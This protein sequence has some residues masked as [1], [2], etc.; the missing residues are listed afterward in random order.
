M[1]AAAAL[2]L[3]AL[4][5]RSTATFAVSAGAESGE[6]PAAGAAPDTVVIVVRH[7]EKADAPRD[8]P[9]L[10][11]RGTERALALAVA[12]ADAGIDAIVTSDLERSRQ[13][14]A[15]AARRYGIRPHAEPLGAAD[16]VDR[17]VAAVAALL[18]GELAGDTV[19]VVG[20]SHTIPRLLE[21]LGSPPVEELC[22]DTDYSKMFVVTLREGR[23][24]RLL[25]TRYGSPDPPAPR[26]C[27]G[28]REAPGR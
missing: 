22:R 11:V 18:R 4:A 8:D 17:H 16:D 6:R 10:T 20:H 24:T 1:V 9:G 12:V 5:W 7:A 21:A 26:G 27:T 3:S 28:G 14:A 2:T 13:T 19:L 23:P 25:R 15:V